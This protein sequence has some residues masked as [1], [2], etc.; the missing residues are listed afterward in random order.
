LALVTTTVRVQEQVYSNLIGQHVESGDV[1]VAAR[2][3]TLA[4]TVL[5][6]AANPQEAVGQA[7]ALLART[8]QREAYVLSYTDAFLLIGAIMLLATALSLALRKTLLPGRFL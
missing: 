8:V 5:P 4:Q 7:T 1:D 2:I 6:R 3:E